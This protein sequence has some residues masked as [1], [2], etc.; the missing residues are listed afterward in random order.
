VCAQG[1]LDGDPLIL[2]LA[3]GFE[4]FDG[5]VMRKML[6]VLGVVVRRV[7]LRVGRRMELLCGRVSGVPRAYGDATCLRGGGKTLKIAPSAPRRR[8]R[9]ERTALDVIV[10]PLGTN[11]VKRRKALEPGLLEL[12]G[13]HLSIAVRVHQLQDGVD[14][15]VRL[16][17][18]VGVVLDAVGW[19]WWDENGG[20]EAYLG[21]LLRIHVV[22]A[23]DGLYFFAV[24]CPVSVPSQNQRTRARDGPCVHGLTGLGRAAGR[25]SR[26]RRNLCGPFSAALT[27]EENGDGIHTCGARKPSVRG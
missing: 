17:L 10:M 11:V 3:F 20:E 25:S 5:L 6:N 19:G 7:R 14:D 9:K 22:N 23:V 1:L 13:G 21:F 27:R 4:P 18:M 16:V 24:P 12:L 26:G 15:V 2:G 8:R